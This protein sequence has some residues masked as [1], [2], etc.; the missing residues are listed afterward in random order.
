MGVRAGEIPFM[1]RGWT[2]MRKPNRKSRIV[3]MK[4]KNVA[5]FDNWRLR[6]WEKNDPA[7]EF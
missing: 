2:S 3:P 6:G 4:E 7:F 1:Y 5:N